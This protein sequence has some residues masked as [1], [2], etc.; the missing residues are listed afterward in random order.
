MNLIIDMEKALRYSVLETARCGETI[1]VSHGRPGNT[2]LDIHEKSCPACQE[3]YRT[4]IIPDY[5]KIDRER[6]EKWIKDWGEKEKKLSTN[7][8]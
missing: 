8:E 2:Q 6:H 5:E 3:S 4:G 1:L 7:E